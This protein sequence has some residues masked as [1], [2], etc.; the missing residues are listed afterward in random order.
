M[1]KYFLFKNKLCPF[2]QTLVAYQEKKIVGEKK[3]FCTSS[4]TLGLNKA[5]REVYME[6]DK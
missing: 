2:L 1:K 4:K 6:V 3:E 5:A